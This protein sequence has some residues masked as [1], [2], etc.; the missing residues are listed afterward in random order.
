M[1]GGILKGV[2]ITV[3]S[4]PYADVKY[5]S[6]AVKRQSMKPACLREDAI[7]NFWYVD[8]RT[9]WLILRL[10]I[11]SAI[12]LIQNMLRSMWESCQVKEIGGRE[13]NFHIT[14]ANHQWW[15]VSK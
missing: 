8:L 9:F 1:N 12:T 15:E 11:E 5:P 14:Q 7:M 4:G 2:N 13:D 6:E 3:W 10:E